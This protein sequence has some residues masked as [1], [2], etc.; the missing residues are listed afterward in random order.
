MEQ[1]SGLNKCLV[2]KIGSCFKI[3]C[4]R[5]SQ[6]AQWV[7]HQ[8]CHCS[9]MGCCCGVGST[10]GSGISI[11]C[12]QGQKNMCSQ[13]TSHCV[14]ASRAAVQMTAN[15]AVSNSRRVLFLGPA[16]RGRQRN[17][18]FLLPLLPVAGDPGLPWLW[19]TPSLSWSPP[20]VF[21]LWVSTHIPLFVFWLRV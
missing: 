9:S 3:R 11:G 10:P 17:P 5:S 14:L 1:K 19:Q 12:G 6:V 7:K 2:L 21:P 18:S 13:N 8:H 16:P 15:P 20:A 4:S